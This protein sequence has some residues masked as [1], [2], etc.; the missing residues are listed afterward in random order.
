[1]A[2][3]EGGLRV[4]FADV[5]EYVAATVG[6]EVAAVV[7]AVA[8]DAKGVGWWGGGVGVWVIDVAGEERGWQCLWD[9]RDIVGRG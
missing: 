2:F 1:M 7:R 3:R 5:V 8:L 4:R 6:V 9:S